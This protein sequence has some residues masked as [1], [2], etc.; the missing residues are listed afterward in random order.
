MQKMNMNNS[1]RGSEWRKWDLHVHTPYSYLNNQFGTNFD[2]YVKKLFIKAIEKDIR[3]IGITDYFCIEGYKK[4]KTEYLPNISK[5]QELFTEEQIAKIKDIVIFPNVEFRLNILANNRRIN[6]HVIFSNED[7]LIKDIEENFLHELD[8]VYEGNPQS[9]DE[10]WKLKISNLEALGK[11]LKKE[12]SNFQESDLLVGMKCAVINHEQISQKL[13]NKKSKFKDK[14][15]LFVPS[16]EDLSDIKWDSQGHNVRKVVIQK[17]DGL[18][19][20]N[21]QTI[22]W[23]LGDLD[24]SDDNFIAEFKTLK[25][26]VWG[27]DAHSY[28]KLF[29]PDN[30]KVC[31]IKADLTFEG[32]KQITYEPRD[33][34][35]IGDEP[36][37]LRRVREN[38]TKYI[39]S[40]LISKND[41]YAGNQGAWFNKNKILFN[42]ELVAII[43]NKGSGKSAVA[44]IVGLLGNTSKEVMEHFSFLEKNKF[45]K[46]GNKNLAQYFKA[47]LQWEDSSCVEKCLNEDVNENEYEKIRYLPQNY[48]N[49]LTNSLD[50]KKFQSTLENVVFSHL[51]DNKKIAG[52]FTE[53]TKLKTESVNNDIQALK[54]TLNDLND[55][56]FKLQKTKHLS[57][58]ER[59]KNLIKEKEQEIKNQDELLRLLPVVQSPS[60][61]DALKEQNNA[62][63]LKIEELNTALSTLI[64]DIDNK[65]K[66]ALRLEKDKLDLEKL[67]Q[68]LKRFEENFGVY[69]KNIDVALL[70]KYGLNIDIIATFG[71]NLL[72]IN[73][74]IEKVKTEIQNFD[75]KLK[76]YNEVEFLQ[77]S[78]SDKLKLQESS[79]L[80]KQKFLQLEI[81]AIKK[82]LSDNEKK[83]QEY[84]ES[85]KRM[86]LKKAEIN[87]SVEKND[88][89]LFYR[90][91]IKFIENNADDG[92]NAKLLLLKQERQ[93]VC[94]KIFDKKSEILDLYRELKNPIDKKVQENKKA[95]D[96]FDINIHVS[97]KLSDD[98][99]NKFLSFINQ[100]R[101]GEF[102]GAE[103]GQKNVKA[104]LDD[105]NNIDKFDN[106]IGICDKL[107]NFLE[108]KGDIMEQVQD[109][110]SLYRFLFE[111][112]YLQAEYKLQLDNKNLNELSAGEKGTLLLVFYLMIDDEGIPLVIDQPE[113]NLD[114]QSIFK[115]LT[116]FIR[117][118]KQKRQIIIVTH[119]PNLAICA[120]AEQIIY[121]KIDKQNN[122]TFS[123]ESGS[124]EN[125]VINNQVVD[126][127]EGTAKAFNTRKLKYHAK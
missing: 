65:K 8:F 14:Y 69:K 124:I 99:S 111:L 59:I 18:F 94:K 31:W 62:K 51:P 6:F 92:L 114:N 37:M 117:F 56:I 54:Q 76:P 48:F 66:E 70:N 121:V 95:L 7:C 105:Y 47:V 71:I 97:F 106:I 126:I 108:D 34:V 32:L 40:L 96:G 72:N 49:D 98:F 39:K 90:E 15:L 79:L 77:L 122:N 57:N 127:L 21:D 42:K 44:D 13:Y 75:L 3:A 11:K 29:N 118:A 16:D 101:T 30:D 103:N 110:K 19:T 28:K 20:S 119:N 81:D 43:G 74:A 82:E 25:P 61:N 73:L 10:K 67:L 17:S 113:D 1:L 112:E 38:K 23:A 50:G 115:M 26:C 87:G 2:E 86:E 100:N 91:E 120:D 116:K 4:I 104:V 85:K 123:F 63:F 9:E 52:D 109:I 125:P 36:P 89:L 27:S 33:R 41:N 80:V 22:K 78:E 64:A 5:L 83:Y 93:D 24:L 35:F 53:L 58:I 88:T 84:I 60:E 12:H 55:E 107:L 102:R 68:D 46:G 45:K